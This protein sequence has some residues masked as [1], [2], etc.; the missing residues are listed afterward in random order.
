MS[1]K[2]QEETEVS[3]TEKGTPSANVARKFDG[4]A[5]PDRPK[6][7]SGEEDADFAGTAAN[8]RAVLK[9]EPTRRVFVPLNPGDSQGSE[10][11]VGINGHFMKVKKGA[12]TNLPETMANIL[13]E[14]L[15]QTDAAAT[16]PVSV[17]TGA[18]LN[19]S[20]APQ[21]VRDALS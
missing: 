16:N 9:S 7:R 15:K 4:E 8:T 19:L 2:K 11:E 12:Y 3:K 20:L 14:S 13:E 5:N 1:T 18:P 17:E 10:L 6:Q 21:E